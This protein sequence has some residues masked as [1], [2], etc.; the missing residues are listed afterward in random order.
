MSLNSISPIDGRYEK[1]TSILSPFFS[2]KALM[3]YRVIV[4]GEYFIALSLLRKTSLR[5]FS[6]TEIKK[7]RS[8]YRLSSKDFEHIKNIEQKTNHDVKAVE[9]FLKEKLAKTSLKKSVE[10]IHFGLTSYDINTVA[11]GMMLG[12][13]LE[14]VIIP[15]IILLTKNINTI[16]K[17]YKALPM[18]SRTHGQSASPTTFG[19]EM[20][21]FEQRLKKQTDI[22][23]FVRIS[24]KFSGATGNF[25]AHHVAYPKVDWIKFAKSF[26]NSLNKNRKIKL[27]LNLPTTQID[28]HDREIEIF[29]CLR[30]IN[31][32]LIDFNQDIWHYISDEWL[33]QKVIKGEV[34]SSAMPHKVNP[35]N[36]ENSEGNL[37]LANALLNFFSNKL[38][39]S[40]LQRDLSDSTVERNF[41]SALAYSLIAYENLLKGLAKI[42]VN[43]Y[44]M[45]KD[46]DNHP[47]VITEAIQTILRREGVAMPYEKLKELTRGK[48]IT[49]GDIHKFIDTL[50]V[51]IEVKKELK[52]YTLIF[53]PDPR[54]LS[55]TVVFFDNSVFLGKKDFTAPAKG[56]KDVSIDWTAT[57][58]TH[59][60][61]G[62]IEN[63]KFLVAKNKY[64]EVYL[65]EN[66]TSKSS[67]TVSKKIVA[68][69][70]DT[71]DASTKISDSIVNKAGN[72]I[73]DSV[74]NVKEAVVAKIPQFVAKPLTLTGNVIEGW[75]SSVGTASENK[76]E[77]VQTDIEK[78]KKGSTK[79]DSKFLEPFKYVELFFFTVLSFIFNSKF[80]FY[81]IL[82]IILALILR[83]IW[84]LIF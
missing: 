83:Y 76:K 18:L 57:V 26:I 78:I 61:F 56:V 48:N 55:G 66:E 67:R 2:E 39:I 58:G 54:E 9:Y 64:E 41:G 77:V 12:D 19:K 45:A 73:S 47:E 27:E 1:Q 21:V 82:F 53:N 32:I 79:N 52:K 30:R 72:A 15:K 14:K 70:I 60:I 31:T 22:L 36:F 42:D 11:R 84:N 81:S 71:A 46:L 35:I 5:K 20:K 43:K 69:I 50:K 3:Q 24:V 63:A 16:S 49:M 10:W 23:E 59:N 40:R 17:K 4:E 7:V 75:R 8:L 44:K 37:G 68:K 80:I 6:N 28:P 25:N 65:A 34:G 13:A 62:K 33:V 29:D 51:S 38:P 74:E